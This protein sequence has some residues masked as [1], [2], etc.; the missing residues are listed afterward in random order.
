MDAFA[1]SVCDG[2]CYRDLNRKKG[3]AI[4][5]T[6]GVFQMA[7]PLI[8]FFVAF[9]LSMVIDTQFID[10]YDHWIAFALLLIIGV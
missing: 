5:L 3:A 4:A 9:G 2:M 6:F 8:G 10:S 7:M 1:V